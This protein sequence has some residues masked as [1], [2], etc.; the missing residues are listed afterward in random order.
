MI[1]IAVV[2]AEQVEWWKIKE[3]CIKRLVADALREATFE[4]SSL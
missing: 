3:I 1:G 4:D 2:D